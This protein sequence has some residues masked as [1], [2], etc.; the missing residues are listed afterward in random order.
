MPSVSALTFVALAPVVGANTSGSMLGNG[1]VVVENERIRVLIEF[2]SWGLRETYYALGSGEP[3]LVARGADAGATFLGATADTGDRSRVASD[4]ATIGEEVIS[5]RL[6][7]ED[8]PPELQPQPPLPGCAVT[9]AAPTLERQPDGAQKLTLTGRTPEGDRIERVLT[10]APGEDFL[11]TEVRLDISRAL[12]VE[13]FEDRLHFLPEGRPDFT[14]A[15]HLKMDEDTVFPDWTLKAPA[16]IVQKGRAAVSLIPDVEDLA[17]DDV[18][19]RCNLT[20]DLDVRPVPG[21]RLSYGLCPTSMMRFH[22]VYPHVPGQSVA[23]DPGTY[24]FSYFLLIAD[25]VPERQ[26]HRRVVRFLWDRFG[27]RACNR[28]GMG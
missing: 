4:Y 7:L 21:P 19:R 17:R 11:R 24:R 25:D 14:W 22:T 12:L 18:W 5:G 13:R 3:V 27:H 2:G 9:Y 10:L 20:L 15:P 6:K 8:I 1:Q 16:A 26:A 28:C 23:L